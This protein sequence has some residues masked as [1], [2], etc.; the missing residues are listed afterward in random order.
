MSP[1][2]SPSPRIPGRDVL[3]HYGLTEPQISDVAVQLRR[4]TAVKDKLKALGKAFGLKP[5]H[6]PA[7]VRLLAEYSD[8]V[9]WNGG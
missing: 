5:K 3:R 6:L 1:P 9:E 8:S 7:R 4:A 2:D